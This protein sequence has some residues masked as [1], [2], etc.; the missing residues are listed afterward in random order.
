MSSLKG[1]PCIGEQPGGHRLRSWKPTQ[2]ADSSIVSHRLWS[3][4][5]ITCFAG[6]RP[7]FIFPKCTT[8]SA[9]VSW[10]G[11]LYRCVWGIRRIPN[12]SGCQK[13]RSK[14]RVKAI[15]GQKTK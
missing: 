4:P 2:T 13:D 6:K 10:H 9:S 8:R 7:N 1:G 15:P 12:V 5:S 14:P 3:K 11:V